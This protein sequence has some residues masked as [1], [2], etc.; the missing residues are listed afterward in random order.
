M[1]AATKP[2]V[3]HVCLCPPL[4]PLFH[5]WSATPAEILSYVYK[6]MAL[7]QEYDVLTIG[8]NRVRGGAGAGGAGE[9]GWERE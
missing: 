4:S 3:K 2:S 5:V 7:Y 1:P 9:R 6:A 8:Q